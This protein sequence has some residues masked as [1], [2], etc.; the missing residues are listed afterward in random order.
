MS[1][2]IPQFLSFRVVIAIVVTM[3][4]THSY[5][6]LGL[7]YIK[8]RT[9]IPGFASFVVSH[10]LPDII[11]LSFPLSIIE[12]GVGS[13]QQTEFVEK[14][15]NRNGLILYKIIAY[16][17]SYQSKTT[18]KPGQLNVLEE[19]IKRGEISER[20][21]PTHFNFDGTI[22]PFAS[23]SV[24]FSYMAHVFHH[25][26]NKQKVLHEIARIT[27]QGGRHFILGATIEDLKQHPLNEFF[28]MKYEYDAKRYPTRFELKQMFKSAGFSY[29]PPFPLGR[30]YATPIDRAFLAGIENTTLDSV[31]RMIK[32]NDASGFQEGV[33]RV[34]KKVERAEKS[35][36]YRA[37]SSDMVKVFWGKKT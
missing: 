19:R 4:I 20:V 1:S 14:E 18:E 16:D 35:G 32:D 8:T 17:K 37:Y 29:E 23:K 15:L 34:K 25:L 26:N 11:D 9:G 6:G 36:S 3:K 30:N 27:R 28:P 12:F 13:G 2:G 31:L 24:D 33:L 21:V 7:D 5:E 22:L 10:I